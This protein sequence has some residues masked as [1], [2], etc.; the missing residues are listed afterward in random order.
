MRNKVHNYLFHQ[1]EQIK[2]LDL[3]FFLCFVV[4]AYAIRL[5]YLFQI[6]DNPFFIPRSLDPLFYHSWAISLSQG[7][8]IGD[9]IFQGMPLYAYFLALV[10]KLLGVDLFAARAIQMVFAACTCGLIYLTGSCTMN[11]LCGLIASLC[12]ILYKPFIFYDGMIIG[13]SITI[14]L[15]TLNLFVA[16]RFIRSFSWWL[17]V[18]WGI[19]TG[20]AALSRPGIMLFPIVTTLVYIL[21]KDHFS[22]SIMLKRFVVVILFMFAVV[23]VATLRNYMI[24][25]QYVTLT[26]HSGLNYFIGNNKEATGKFHAPAGVGRQSNKMYENSRAIAQKELG[27]DLTPAEV[28]AYWKHKANQ[29]ILYH[30]VQFMLLLGKKIYLFWQGGEVADFRNIEFFK[31][32]SALMRAKLLSFYLIVPWAIIG[33]ILSLFLNRYIP[34][35]HCFLWSYFAT[36]LM[37][38]INSRYRLAVLS[39]LLLFAAY[40]VVATFKCL[41]KNIKIFSLLMIGI[42]GLY[43]ILGFNMEKPNLA[44]DYNELAS[45]YM[46]DQHDYDKAIALYHQA[47]RLDPNNQYVYFNLGKAYFSLNRI[48]EALEQFGKALELNKKDFESMNF[49]GILLSKKG[50]HD[51]AIDFFERAISL[52]PDYYIALNNMAAVYR[53][54]GDEQNALKTWNRSLTVN[55]DQPDIRSKLYLK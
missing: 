39:V 32:F 55:P 15:Y 22:R 14:F 17:A 41:K 40:G 46:T 11:R 48:D 47:L 16:A 53:L 10:Y 23:S 21:R 31:R 12:A 51:R 30:P 42:A 20:I 25:G 49:Y 35:L 2:K 37:Y 1:I 52:Q 28:S 44:D 6:K 7:N 4:G 33:M 26:A 34:L 43:A 50:M 38:F 24:S 13:T 8:W 36:L 5:L 27:R 54:M 19:L 18:L 3:V 29:F 9:D 45:W